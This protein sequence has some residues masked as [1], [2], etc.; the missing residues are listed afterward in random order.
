MQPNVFA[1]SSVGVIF[2]HLETN[3]DGPSLRPLR[4]CALVQSRHA[5]VVSRICPRIFFRYLKGEG[6]RVI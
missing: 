5:L 4:S 1:P 3:V 2:E 6:Q